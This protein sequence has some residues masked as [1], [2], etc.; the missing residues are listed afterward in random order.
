MQT[1]AQ[2][3]LGCG[4][5]HPSALSACSGSHGL[6]NCLA[7][8]PSQ[9]ALA[10]PLSS[11]RGISSKTPW[12]NHGSTTHLSEENIVI[13]ELQGICVPCQVR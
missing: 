7:R 5:P 12:V 8:V 9:P 11:Q 1:Q 13:P 6:T 3:R 4:V 2:A 10:Q